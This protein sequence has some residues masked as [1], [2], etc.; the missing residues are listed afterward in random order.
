MGRIAVIIPAF[1]AAPYIGRCI[2]S[3]LAQRADVGELEVVVV[4]DGSTDETAALA[5][6]YEGVK[7]VS[8]PN[9]GLSAARNT[10]VEATDAPWLTFVDADDLLLPGALQ[11]LRAGSMTAPVVSGAITRREVG[12]DLPVAMFRML[13]AE[14]AICEAL[15]QRTSL[16]SSACGKLVARRI[17]EKVPFREGIAYEDLDWFYRAF[18]EA[19]FVAVT[20]T[21]VYFYSCTPGSVTNVFSPRRLDVLDVTRRIEEW[22]SRRTPALLRAARERR[23][24][25]S[26]DMLTRLLGS[27]VYRDDQALAPR[28]AEAYAN[29][30]R[31]RAATIFSPRT[32]LKSRLGALYSYLGVPAMRLAARLTRRSS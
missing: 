24:S 7:V 32:R 28:L 10:G 17:V 4:D 11:T 21:P 14:E 29:V 16:N 13:D 18:E 23:L 31:L 6:S 19:R 2:E 8:R 12:A 9:G 20:D 5:A 1:N 25:A 15:Y 30:R 26:L 3:V 27:D 22:A